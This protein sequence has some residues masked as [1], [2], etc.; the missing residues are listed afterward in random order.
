LENFAHG[1]FYCSAALKSRRFVAI[2][3]AGFEDAADGASDFGDTMSL[4][5]KQKVVEETVEMEEEEQGFVWKSNLLPYKDE[6]DFV[7]PGSSKQHASTS[8]ERET[9]LSGKMDPRIDRSGSNGTSK[10]SGGQKV[11]SFSFRIY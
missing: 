5:H 9:T 11:N 2:A 3:D 10:A 7:L 8:G 6:D 4:V 1:D